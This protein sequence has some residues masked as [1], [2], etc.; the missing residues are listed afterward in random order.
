MQIIKV[1]IIWRWSFSQTFYILFTANWV[2]QFEEEKTIDSTFY[3]LN[4]DEL[5]T[6]MMRFDS[7]ELEK[8][9]FKYTHSTDLNAKVC[10][11]IYYLYYA[12]EYKA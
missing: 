9:K 8:K 5:Q 6:K 12:G 3:S 10:H 4:G 2:C 7:I 11:L 1:N